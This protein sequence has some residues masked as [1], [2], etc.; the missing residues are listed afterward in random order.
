MVELVGLPG[1]GKS[2]LAIQLEDTLKLEGIPV[3]GLR[4]AAIRAIAA[5]RPKIGFIKG[6]LERQSLYGA[7]LFSKAHPELFHWLHKKSLSDFNLLLWNTEVMSQIGIV[8]NFAKPDMVVINDEG[9]IQRAASTMLAKEYVPDINDGSALFPDNSFT[10]FLELDAAIAVKRNLNRERAFHSILKGDTEAGTVANF[11]AYQNILRTGVEAH[12][13]RGC[14][15]LTVD[16]ERDADALGQSVVDWLRPHLPAPKPPR[17]IP[18]KRLER[19]QK[20][21]A[22]RRS[23]KA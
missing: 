3:I 23:A 16:A 8:E 22:A 5:Q 18:A 2:T 12:Q 11:E 7:M 4:D 15:V 10:I 1:S 14:Q 17:P 9:F 13:K 21:L 19:I 20:K 6:R